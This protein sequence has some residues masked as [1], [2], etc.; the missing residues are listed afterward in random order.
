MQAVRARGVIA[1][2][3]RH[4]HPFPFHPPQGSLA[5]NPDTC[6][7]IAFSIIANTKIYDSD[8]GTWTSGPRMGTARHSAAAVALTDG[9]VLVLG[10]EDELGNALSCTEIF[11]PAD[12]SWSM[13]PDMGG[14]RFCAAAVSLPHG[15]ALVIGGH[16]G[17]N[18]LA[19][20]LICP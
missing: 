20:T 19:S 2:P 9:R 3:N 11:D 12:N 5:N 15:K 1:Q 13:G 6:A 17:A 16:D 4:A 8:A 7:L 10:G 14:A 18:S